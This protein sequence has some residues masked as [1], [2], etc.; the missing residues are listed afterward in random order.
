MQNGQLES[1][2]T[3]SNIGNKIL[4]RPDLQKQIAQK[5]IQQQVQAQLMFKSLLHLPNLTQDLQLLLQRL[6]LQQEMEKQ[7]LNSSMQ[8]T[9]IH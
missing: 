2:H 1:Q 7:L 6:L 4:A 3:Q 9:Y 5:L 8:E